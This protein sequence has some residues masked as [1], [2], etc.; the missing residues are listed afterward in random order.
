MKFNFKIDYVSFIVRSHLGVKCNRRHDDERRER[1]EINIG[2]IAC[3]VRNIKPMEFA[4]YCAHI[5]FIYFD[6]FTKKKSVRNI[7]TTEILL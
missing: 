1:K 4:A 5:D 2:H 6:K 7:N 3:S